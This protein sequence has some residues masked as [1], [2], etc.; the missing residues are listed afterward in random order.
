M[1]VALVF[2]RFKHRN[3][4]AEPLGLL[5]IAAILK[6]NG[7]DVTFFDG[8]VIDKEEIIDKIVSGKYDY[9][10][11]SVQTI[12]ADDALDMARKIKKRSPKIK[13]VFGGPHASAH[14]NPIKGVDHVVVGEGEYI[15]LDL[16]KGKV[17][18]KVI[19]AEPIKNMDEIPLPARE[20]LDKRYFDN[21]TP[22][23]MLSRG[24]PFRCAFCQTTLTK[25]FGL[26]CRR[27]SIKR[28]IEEIRNANKLYKKM[29]AKVTTYVFQD[30]AVTYNKKWLQDFCE[31]LINKKLV[32]PWVAGSRADTLPSD[33]M[34]QLMKDS[35]CKK[36]S[37][38]VESGNDYIR[39]TILQ[40]NLSKNKIRDAFKRLHKVGIGSHSFL[41]VGSP[42]ETR[43]TVLETVELLD[44]IEPTA[45]QVTVTT[46]IPGTTLYDYCEA[47]ELVNPGTFSDYDYY[48]NSRLNLDTLQQNEID[49]LRNAVNYSIIFR[50][51]IHRKLKVKVRYKTLFKIFQ[52]GMI[53]KMMSSFERGTMSFF[54][55]KVQGAFKFSF[56]G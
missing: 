54:R 43:A 19:K 48:F 7:I 15:F 56:R 6:K 45:A 49:T 30:D 28:S 14:P 27:F 29:G 9:A 8:T 42:G 17:R 16:I 13:T 20:L 26:T 1:K 21:G 53:N 39:N 24:C 35:G 5:Y 34:L 46:P 12:Y 4:A 10:G 25:I 41:M 50:N 3:F 2:P 52:M 40:K 55:Y 11:F 51:L 33:D 37:I 44:E 36:L 22:N 18:G 32:T 38:G 31:T 47:N 23:F